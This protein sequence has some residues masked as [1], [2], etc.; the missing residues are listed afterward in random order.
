MYGRRRSGSSCS[1]CSHRSL[2]A[3][4]SFQSPARE[5]LESLGMH[6]AFPAGTVLYQEG[7]QTDSVSII[8]E[9]QVKLSCS[10]RSGKSLILR[11]AGAGELLGLSSTITLTP[12]ETTAEVIAPTRLKVIPRT[13][14]LAFFDEFPEVGT[15][16]AQVLALEYQKTFVDAKRLALSSS[17]EARLGKVLLDWGRSVA[18]SEELRFQMSLSHSELGEMAGLSRETVTRTLASL[19]QKKVLSIQGATMRIL[20]P[21]ALEALCS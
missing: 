17:A 2:Y 11:I 9:G 13:H 3:F 20:Q 14:F 6:V 15:H 1:D 12:H 5:R 10:S 4:C 16:S 18:T 21:G 19:R 8:C 7:E